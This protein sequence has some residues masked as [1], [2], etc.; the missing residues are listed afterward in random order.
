MCFLPPPLSHACVPLLPCVYVWVQ[1]YPRLRCAPAG[2]TRGLWAW[3]HDM[4][5]VSAHGMGQMGACVPAVQYVNSGMGRVNSELGRINSGQNG[6]GTRQANG[7]RYVTPA[8]GQDRVRVGMG[9]RAY[10][11]GVGTLP[12]PAPE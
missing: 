10:V 4:D 6:L 3:Q 9:M 2:L 5:R 7:S 12:P 1:N 8:A 11:L